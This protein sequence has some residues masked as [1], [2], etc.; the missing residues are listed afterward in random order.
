MYARPAPSTTYSDLSVLFL[1]IFLH[2]ATDLAGV[3]VLDF[4]GNFACT[5]RAAADLPCGHL[6]GVA[7]LDRR[8]KTNAIIFEC[9]GIVATNFGQQRTRG[10][11]EGREAVEN[12]TAKTRRLANA[13]VFMKVNA[14]VRRRMEGMDD[15]HQCEAG[16]SRR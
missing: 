12:D 5:I 15:S 14:Y 16:C 4:E 7:G 2:L 9:I 11:A 1:I 8:R 6:E 13:R 3:D 10:K